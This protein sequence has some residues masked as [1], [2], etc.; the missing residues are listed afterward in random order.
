MD[1]TKLQHL[2]CR[3]LFEELVAGS[4]RPCI[5]QVDLRMPP[6]VSEELLEALYTQYLLPRAKL[7][8]S[9]I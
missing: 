7:S 9:V 5:G 2:P 6:S 8:I 3:C 4:S 1:P